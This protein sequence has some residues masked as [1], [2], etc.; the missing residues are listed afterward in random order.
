MNVYIKYIKKNY[1]RYSGYNSSISEYREVLCLQIINKYIIE[2]KNISGNHFPKLIKYKKGNY[3]ILSNQGIDLQ[4]IK[5]KRIKIKIYN[6]DKQIK[7]IY[8]ILDKCKI[9][10]LDINDN[11]KNI[12]INQNGIISLIDFDII[13]FIKLDTLDNL[14]TLML[15]RIRKYNYCYTYQDFYK[16]IFN[17]IK[18]CPNIIII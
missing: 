14:T 10:H 7:S 3:I 11:G 12:C 2:N 8:N 16:K 15:D 9:A 6:I 4:K 1:N 5:K 17:I 13:H 18:R